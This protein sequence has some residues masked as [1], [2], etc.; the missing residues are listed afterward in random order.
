MS[1]RLHSIHSSSRCNS[2]V[3]HWDSSSSRSRQTMPNYNGVVRAKTIKHCCSPW[4]HSSRS[5]CET[6]LLLSINKQ[7]HGWHD[8]RVER[9]RWKLFNL[10]A[11]L[12]LHIFKHSINISREWSRTTPRLLLLSFLTWIEVNWCQPRSAANLDS[13]G[14]STEGEGFLQLCC[15][16]EAGKWTITAVKR[17][18]RNHVS[19]MLSVVKWP[20]HCWRLMASS[21]LT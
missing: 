10:L 3:L 15:A 1:N 14:M 4:T 13:I 2:P 9:S 6:D 12:V 20:A 8:R 17:N 5:S 16:E 18:Y 19:K 11:D 21:S 7:I